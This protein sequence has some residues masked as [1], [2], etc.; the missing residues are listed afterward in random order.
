MH[1]IQVL[2]GMNE[3][4][5]IFEGKWTAAKLF[6]LTSNMAIVPVNESLVVEMIGRGIEW[7]D[8]EEI[9][10]E[11]DL[12]KILEPILCCLR[13]SSLP[14]QVVF[15]M[16]QYFGGVGA[17]VAALVDPKDASDRVFLGLES[18]NTALSELGVC[19][20]M[21]TGLDE[22]ATIGL[23]RWRSNNDLLEDFVSS[24]YSRK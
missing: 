15:L 11:E 22:F 9:V 21:A 1:E 6:P 19:R 4:M 14:G 5:E 10:S 3:V 8:L 24:R 12:I 16:T 23:G 18:I 2:V 17:Q 7:P 20:D 13:K